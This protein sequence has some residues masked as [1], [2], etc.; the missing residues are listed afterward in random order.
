MYI[1]QDLTLTVSIGKLVSRVNHT[2]DTNIFL[3]GYVFDRIFR[4]S[5][6]VKYQ[7]SLYDSLSIRPVYWC[8]FNDICNLLLTYYT[9][10][11][12]KLT[13]LTGATYC[14]PSHSDVRNG[15]GLTASAAL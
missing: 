8:S 11:I 14:V 5:I 12:Q 9:C 6:A 4:V 10:I 7:I 3:L 15:A 2:T 1:T 13:I